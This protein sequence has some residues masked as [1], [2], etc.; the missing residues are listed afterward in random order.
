M[1]SLSKD[2]TLLSTIQ[3]RVHPKCQTK[4]ELSRT[5]TL[6]H[7][8]P[9]IRIR[10]HRRRA[11]DEQ[12]Q[13]L[14]PRLECRETDQQRGFIL[15]RAYIRSWVQYRLAVIPNAQSRSAGRPL[16]GSFASA[17]IFAVGALF[18]SAC[19]SF[20]SVSPLCC[21]SPHSAA[22]S[23]SRIA[24]FC[25]GRAATLREPAASQRPHER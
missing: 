8:G 14:L 12:S 11:L 7:T 9:S 2:H 19:A 13:S 17:A 24:V 21:S 16:A 6:H 10:S 15:W 18:R 20:R 22:S 25:P 4:E 23:E 1:A 3:A 5:P